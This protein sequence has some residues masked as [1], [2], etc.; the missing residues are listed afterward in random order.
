VT[1]RGHHLADDRL[2][3]C[4][5]AA[6][7]GELLDPS[8]AEHL[9]ECPGCARRF[10][11]LSGLLDDMRADAD[12][13]VDALFAPGRLRTGQQQIAQRLEQVG[14]SSRVLA[15]PTPEPD[16]RRPARPARW[17]P[18][19][20]AAV[21]AAGLA[22]GAGINI[23][24][25]PASRRPAHPTQSSGPAWPSAAVSGPAAVV[26]EVDEAFF[27]ELEHAGDGPRTPELEALD[28]LTPH[29]VEAS[30]FGHLR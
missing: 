22:L 24:L 28:A 13:A 6:R 5:F 20:V 4:Y 17:M 2:A 25:G 21:A 11:D 9:G 29:I 23:I 27:F 26:P 10:Q 7:L 8:A 1:R 3:E 12:R 14:R 15:F 18:R 16:R 30:V 19:W